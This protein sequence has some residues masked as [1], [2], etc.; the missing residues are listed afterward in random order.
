MNLKAVSKKWSDIFCRVA[1]RDDGTPRFSLI[2]AKG[3]LY[4][5]LGYS[6]GH[7]ELDR[8]IKILNKEG[9]K[10]YASESSSPG[11]NVAS[12]EYTYGFEDGG[13]EIYSGNHFC[14][15]PGHGAFAVGFD[16]FRWLLDQLGIRQPR[17]FK[18]EWITVAEGADGYDTWWN[19]LF[20]P[21]MKQI[22]PYLYAID[23]HQLDLDWREI[24]ASVPALN[25]TDWDIPKENTW[26]IFLD[27]L[28]FY[29]GC[30]LLD[31]V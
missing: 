11:L 3:Y 5:G 31:R 6:G 9:I 10:C 20:A 12:F 1:N 19:E 13:L 2:G 14:G 16:A 7:E 22:E 21:V 28:E 15:P 27:N 29:M 17:R 18:N 23:E 30:N 24:C 8:I 26:S 25:G 4:S